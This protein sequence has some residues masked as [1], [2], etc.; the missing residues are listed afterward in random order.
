[1]VGGRLQIVC[2]EEEIKELVLPQG[3]CACGKRRPWRRGRRRSTEEKEQRDLKRRAV[4]VRESDGWS[5]ASGRGGWQ[6]QVTRGLL[7]FDSRRWPVA[8]GV[9]HSHPRLWG[10]LRTMALFECV[11]QFSSWPLSCCDCLL[12]I[13]AWIQIRR[14]VQLS[15]LCM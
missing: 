9:L 11:C 1:M 2:D 15:G 3:A 8:A 14:R 13:I 7:P 10:K 5:R 12:C 4:H 6:V